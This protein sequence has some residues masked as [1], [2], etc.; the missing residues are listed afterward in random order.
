MKIEVNGVHINFELS[1][2][3]DGP[4]VMLSHSLS[5]HLAMWDLQMP[6]LEACWLECKY[7]KMQR[8]LQPGSYFIIC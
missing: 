7:L 8:I 1:G 2:K 5:T 4:V 3:E 6:V